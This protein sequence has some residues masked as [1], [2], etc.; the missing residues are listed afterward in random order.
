[1]KR[2][3]LSDSAVRWL[4]LTAFVLWALVAG[5]LWWVHHRQAVTAGRLRA[6]E[7][8]LRVAEAGQARVVVHLD[9]VYRQDTVWR[10]RTTVLYR[11][12]TQQ[13]ATAPAVVTAHGDSLRADTLPQVRHVVQA[14]TE[15]LA[16]RDTVVSVCEQRLAAQRALALTD[17]TRQAVRYGALQLESRAVARKAQHRGRVQGAL[18]AVLVLVAAGFAVHQLRF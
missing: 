17:S 7:D 5:A 6:R 2:L 11:A 10:T 3:D 1:M 8:S 15:A 4:L 12:A 18:G 13:L 14:C 9:T 16:A